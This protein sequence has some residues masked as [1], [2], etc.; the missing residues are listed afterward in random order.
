[1]TS[2]DVAALYARIHTA[3]VRVNDRLVAGEPDCDALS[4]VIAAIDVDLAAIPLPSAIVDLDQNNA[5][6]LAALARTCDTQRQQALAGLLVAQQQLTRT[7]ANDE[8]ASRSA[9]A[10]QHVEGQ[11]DGRFV[12]QRR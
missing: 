7:A 8:R 1:M 12:D 4:Q 3:Y 5:T 11:G 9:Q 2:A 6:T 10:Y